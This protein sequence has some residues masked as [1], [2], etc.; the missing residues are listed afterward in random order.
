MT[1]GIDLTRKLVP[2]HGISLQTVICPKCIN[3]LNTASVGLIGQNSKLISTCPNCSSQF[4]FEPIP[5]T[6]FK[7]FEVIPQ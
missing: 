2:I 6:L 1:Q 5:I 3:F 4:V 7:V